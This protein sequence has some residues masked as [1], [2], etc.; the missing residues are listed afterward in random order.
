MFD[1]LYRE[2][3]P[4]HEEIALHSHLVHENIVEYLGSVSEDG[5]IKIFMELVPGGIVT[6]DR[7]ELHSF[8]CALQQYWLPQNLLHYIF[9]R[10]VEALNLLIALTCALVF[11]IVH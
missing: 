6:C 3:Q 5:F 9:G 11:L 4:L 8:Q 1:Q 10:E 2:V 7:K